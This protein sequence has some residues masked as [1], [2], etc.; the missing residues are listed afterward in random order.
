MAR[1]IITEDR[2]DII[3]PDIIKRAEKELRDISES[4]RQLKKNRVA[5][6]INR[7]T[8][9]SAVAFEHDGCRYHL[10][11]TLKEAYYMQQRKPGKKVKYTPRVRVFIYYEIRP[12]GTSDI[13]R[14]WYGNDAIQMRHMYGYEK[15]LSERPTEN[16]LESLADHNIFRFVKKCFRKQKIADIR[17]YQIYETITNHIKM[18]KRIDP[19]GPQPY[20]DTCPGYLDMK[21]AI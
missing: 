9:S 21:K 3:D 6:A 11:W 5:Q 4:G 17:L 14:G 20:V 10:E 1:Q 2:R 12:N 15:R 16:F 7:I 19:E 8:D 18:T 13:Y